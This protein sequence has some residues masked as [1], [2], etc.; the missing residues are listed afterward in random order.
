M[1]HKQTESAKADSAIHFGHWLKKQ[2]ENLGVS[3]E[4]FAFR[5]KV[6]YV[7]LRYWM[8]QPAPNIRGFRRVLLAKAL[9]I[10]REE[11]DTILADAMAANPTADHISAA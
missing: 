4:V 1:A 3:Q 10:T 9:K 6:A 2:I 7:S 11:L 8:N 5:A